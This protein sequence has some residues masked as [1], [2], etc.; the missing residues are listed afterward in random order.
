MPVQRATL[1]LILLCATTSHRGQASNWV[2]LN[3]QPQQTVV[4]TTRQEFSPR[5]GGQLV[6][7]DNTELVQT[8]SGAL[9]FPPPDEELRMVYLAGDDHIV[10]SGG[11][12]YRNDVWYLSGL[13][14][15]AVQK[16]TER[17]RYSARVP[18]IVSR[19]TWKQARL[20]DVLRSGRY[21][22]VDNGGDVTPPEG[23]MYRDWLCCVRGANIPCRN[24]IECDPVDP[25]AGGRRFS[26]RRNFATAVIPQSGEVPARLVV[27][28]GRARALEDIPEDRAVGGIIPPRQISMEKTLLTNDI[29]ESYNGEEWR[30]ISPGCWVQQ[31]DLVGIYVEQGDLPIGPGRDDET[32]TT[33]EDCTQVYRYGSATC[34][35]G[36]CVCTRWGPREGHRVVYFNNALYMLGGLTYVTKHRCSRKACGGE[37]T[38]YLN[39]VWVA[40]NMNNLNTWR[41]L[42]AIGGGFPARANFE[43]VTHTGAMYIM[44]GEK[45]DPFDFDSTELYND[46]WT[47]VDGREWFEVSPQGGDHWSPR[48]SLAAAVWQGKL[49]VA[50]GYEI[51][52]PLPSPSPQTVV[53]LVDTVAAKNPVKTIIQQPSPSPF[54]DPRPG[55]VMHDMRIKPMSDVWIYDLNVP[56]EE[57]PGWIQDFSGATEFKA[58]IAMEDELSAP[59]V[60]QFYNL[61][62]E[63][64]GWFA[65]LGVTTLQDLTE[66]EASVMEQL[67]DQ[68][69][70]TYYSD[71]C[72][73]RKLAESVAYK[74]TYVKRGHASQEPQFYEIR[75]GLDAPV[76]LREEVEE[77]E[78][79]T[80]CEGTSSFSTKN[81]ICRFGFGEARYSLKMVNFN[82][83]LAMVGGYPTQ[84]HLNDGTWYKD[85]DIPASVLTKA[86]SSGSYETGFEFFA[87]ERACTFEYRVW[88]LEQDADD[89]VIPFIGS[90]PSLARDWTPRGSPLDLDDLLDS[91]FWRL[92]LRAIDPAGNREE[93][94]S[95]GRN[96]YEWEYVP[97]I[98]WLLIILG[99]FLFVS[100]MMAFVTWYRRRKRRRL[101]ERYAMK[102]MRK[103]LKAIQDGG[104]DGFDNKKDKKKKKRVTKGEKERRKQAAKDEKDAKAKDKTKKK[105]KSKGKDG[106]SVRSSKSKK[107][108]SSSKTKTSSKS[109]SS[110]KTSKSKRSSSKSKGGKSSSKK[111]SSSK[112]KKKS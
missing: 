111:R 49:V 74:C 22:V 103:K 60:A 58:Y 92:E 21:E 46:V 90:N 41:R 54:V 52:P 101:M 7:L 100:L 32:C 76:D 47:S 104:V 14:V 8:P 95:L 15:E 34:Q 19:S 37:Y 23:V 40:E 78:V 65:D 29:W 2:Q 67:M 55:E 6:V 87:D 20:P 26:P 107:T 30:L 63:Q 89:N 83:E 12:G 73:V 25:F 99:I 31:P 16:L 56:R 39:D 68:D 50:G 81:F 36:R 80:G 1:G 84:S 75:D 98:P 106:A 48:A 110:S 42:E 109:R 28:G 82:G 44:G 66:A 11:G 38:H 97:P 77:E 94:I 18:K 53:Q 64:L 102:R 70:T 61:T 69:G 88:Q 5:W 79:I 45:G 86:P 10:D 91:G 96:A 85:D 35:F 51:V 105:S 43:V 13:N 72:R 24:G 17:T 112:K 59:S 108:R 27:L 93:L 62:D 57:N 71:A 9:R 3:G 4:T 33:A